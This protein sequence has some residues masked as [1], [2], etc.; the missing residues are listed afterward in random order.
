[1]LETDNKCLKICG[2]LQYISK[3]FHFTSKHIDYYHSVNEMI[4]CS[5]WSYNFNM[6]Y[7]T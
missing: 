3:L 1:M 7:P 4:I 2:K 5:T 6:V